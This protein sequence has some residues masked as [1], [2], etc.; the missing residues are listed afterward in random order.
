MSPTTVPLGLLLNHGGHHG[1][2]YMQHLYRTS[3]LA[4]V[5]CGTIKA[6]PQREDFQVRSRLGPPVLMSKA[7]GV[8]YHSC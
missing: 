2:S 4:I 8:F 7:R 3:W 6:N 1:S 5:L